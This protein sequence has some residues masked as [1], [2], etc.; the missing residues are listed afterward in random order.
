MARRDRSSRS[1]GRKKSSSRASTTLLPS[2]RTCLS[3][4][5]KD[6]HVPALQNRV[7]CRVVI[8]DYGTAFIKR[9]AEFQC[10]LQSTVA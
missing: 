9:E 8:Y 7:H 1:V 6:D 2:K 3:S 5:S 10:Y 4:P